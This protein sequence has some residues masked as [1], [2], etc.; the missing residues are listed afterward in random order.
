MATGW[1]DLKGD[2][3]MQEGIAKD[4]LKGLLFP[5]LIFSL[6]KVLQARGGRE[7]GHS[8]KTFD[9]TFSQSFTSIV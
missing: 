2:G 9:F 7:G 5:N 1:E 3:N 6:A 4:G 8:G